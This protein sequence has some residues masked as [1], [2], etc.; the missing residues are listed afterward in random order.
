MCGPLQ[1][2]TT[3]VARKQL[4]PVYRSVVLTGVCRLASPLLEVFRCIVMRGS[5]LGVGIVWNSECCRAACS[6]WLALRGH[7]CLFRFLG[8]RRLVLAPLALALS[9]FFQSA[10]RARAHQFESAARSATL[11]ER[12][13]AIVCL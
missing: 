9:L 12:R 7:T 8:A 1:S 3:E 4:N 13:S 10:A 11:F 2:N 5:S 6:A